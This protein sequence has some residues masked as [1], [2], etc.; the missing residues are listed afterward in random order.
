VLRLKKV[1]HEKTEEKKQLP[2][3]P[4]RG[5]LSLLLLCA[6]IW[7]TFDGNQIRVLFFVPAYSAKPSKKEQRDG[8]LSFGEGEAESACLACLVG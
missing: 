3:N 4:G 1:A 8:V 5:R 2:P 7:S 6:R